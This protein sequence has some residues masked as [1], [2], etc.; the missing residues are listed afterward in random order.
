MAVGRTESSRSLAREPPP[1]SLIGLAPLLSLLFQVLL[2]LGFQG[3]AV[4]L[5]WRQPFYEPAHPDN[6]EELVCQDNYAIFA[7]SVFQYITLAVVFS[8]GSPYRKPIYTN[9]EFLTSQMPQFNSSCHRYVPRLARCHDYLHHLCRCHS[10]HVA[11]Q[12][13]RGE[14]L[15]RRM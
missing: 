8:K 11:K 5:L 4:F 2:I 1:S 10:T 7:V 15:I 12:F 9:C 3:L 6:P 13:F 14:P